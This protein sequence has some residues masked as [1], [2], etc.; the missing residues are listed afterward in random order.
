MYASIIQ[1][2]RPNSM[3]RGCLAMKRIIID[4]G[5]RIVR[6]PALHDALL[7]EISIK[8]DRICLRFDAPNLGTVSVLLI[9]VRA[10]SIDSITEQNVVFQITATPVAVALPDNFRR[11]LH[12]TQAVPRSDGR[13]TT[14]MKQ[15]LLFLAIEPST[16]AD[17]LALCREAVWGFGDIDGEAA[18]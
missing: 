6:E 5:S 17:V 13:V 4:Q 8:R 10:L 12:L 14:L 3:M 1:Q 9:D 2:H 18:V 15:D 7:R 11:V 16:G